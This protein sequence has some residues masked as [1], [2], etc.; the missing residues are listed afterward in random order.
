MN[1]Y[2]LLLFLDTIASQ[3]LNSRLANIIRSYEKDTK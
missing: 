2:K 3:Y 1:K